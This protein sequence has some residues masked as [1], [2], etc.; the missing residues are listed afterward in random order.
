MSTGCPFLTVLCSFCY[1][2]GLNNYT[3][4]YARLVTRLHVETLIAYGEPVPEE[5]KHPHAI[6]MNVVA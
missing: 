4:F 5:R 6:I 3:P 1:R 2:F